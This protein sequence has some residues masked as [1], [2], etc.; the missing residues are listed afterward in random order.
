MKEPVPEIS[1]PIEVARVS[2]VGSHEKISADAKECAALAK[3][4]MLPAVHAVS[5]VLLVKPWRGGGYKVTGDVR[6]DIEQESVISLETFRSDVV[7]PVE[8]Y[9]LSHGRVE[10]DDDVDV[11]EGGVIDLGEVVAETL[12]LEL[13]PYPRKPGE[14]FQSAGEE[15]PTPVIK[16]SP[17]AALKNKDKS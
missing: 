1:R 7:F 2:P 15:E 14:A 8:R 9:F 5:A 11:I 16:L 4:L 3:R 13:D 12:G 17:F 10:S 6:A